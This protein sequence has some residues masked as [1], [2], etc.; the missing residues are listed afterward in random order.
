MP[1]KPKFTKEEIIAA[2]LE[3]VSERGMSET[4]G[5]K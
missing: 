4:P 2:A 1:P 5:H 3:L